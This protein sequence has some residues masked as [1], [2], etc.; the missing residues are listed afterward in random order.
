MKQPSDQPSATPP[1][2]VSGQ[3][4]R[5]RR[6]GYRGVIVDVDPQ[7]LASEQWYQNNKT[8]PNRDQ[9]WYHVLIDGSGGATYP[10]QDSLEPDP[11]GLPVD[12]PLIAQFFDGFHDG[13]YLRNGEPWIV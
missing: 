3:L 5:H 7:C 9:P 6:Y 1:L 4:I 10:A 2:Y 8:Q 13:R 12:H 11:S